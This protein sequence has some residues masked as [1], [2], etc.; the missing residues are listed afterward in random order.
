MCEAADF[1]C[2][3]GAFCVIRAWMFPAEWWQK[4]EINQT[5]PPVR[6]AVGDI[7]GIR[8]VM[9]HPEFF[10]LGK[11]LFWRGRIVDMLHA[12]A[13]VGGNDA[14][15]VLVRFQQP[16]HKV[17]AARLEV[18]QDMHFIG[19]PFVGLG[20]VV[21]LDHP[22]IKAEMDGGPK[23]VFDFEHTELFLSFHYYPFWTRCKCAVICAARANFHS[24]F[25]NRS[26]TEWFWENC[27]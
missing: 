16:R 18:A 11:Q 1:G 22:A 13:A 25:L 23:R 14:K 3:R 4:F 6:E 19:E 15:I 7:A 26:T 9:A 10:Q 21:D 17:A 2:R 5:K 8:V 27:E 20:T 12:G 24:R